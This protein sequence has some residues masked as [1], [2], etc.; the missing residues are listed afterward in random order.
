MLTSPLQI[1]I[2]VSL[3]F[4]VGAIAALTSLWA[5]EW[6]TLVLSFQVTP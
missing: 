1:G 3:V 4:S 5:D 6:E 2:G